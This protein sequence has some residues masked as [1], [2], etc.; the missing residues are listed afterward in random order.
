[1]QPPPYAKPSP[2]FTFPSS[3]GDDG[4]AAATFAPPALTSLPPRGPERR[5]FA[6]TGP[7]LT[8]LPPASGY[9]LPRRRMAVA[10]ALL[11]VGLAAFIAGLAARPHSVVV[12]LLGLTAAAPGAYVL[13]RM[14]P[15]HGRT[16]PPLLPRGDAYYDLDVASSGV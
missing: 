15:W 10:A 7:V 5:A 4:R 1:M 12:A 3:S 11:V 6:P 16:G 13:C 9:T 8:V 2:D 14:V